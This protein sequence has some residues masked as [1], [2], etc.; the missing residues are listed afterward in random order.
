MTTTII[1]L[2]TKDSNHKSGYNYYKEKYGDS[3]EY[4]GDSI[5][6]QPHIPKSIWYNPYHKQIKK[7]GRE[8]VILK[9]NSYLPTQKH[10]MDSLHALTDKVLGCWCKPLPCHGDVLMMCLDHVEKWSDMDSFAMKKRICELLED[11]KLRELI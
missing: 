8:Q 1:N 10:L 5:R 6:F 4:I 11:S 7:L 2:R 3:F 9:Y